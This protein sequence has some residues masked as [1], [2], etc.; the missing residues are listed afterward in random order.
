[1]CSTIKILGFT[2]DFTT[3]DLCGKVDL[4]G[5]YAVENE[6][7]DVFYLGSVCISKRF[8]LSS[9]EVKE[10][11]SKFNREEKRRN[12]NNALIAKYITPFLNAIEKEKSYETNGLEMLERSKKS[13]IEAF[14]GSIN[15]LCRK[16]SIEI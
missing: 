9:T 6:S 4:K 13:N 7:G 1:M 14:M 10:E 8:A 5:T 3:C 16:Y 11:I 2:E 15:L 12:K